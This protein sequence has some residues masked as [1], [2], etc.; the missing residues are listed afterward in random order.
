MKRRRR[1]R[2]KPVRDPRLV[3]TLAERNYQRRLPGRVIDQ[4]FVPYRDDSIGK[5]FDSGAQTGYWAHTQPVKVRGFLDGRLAYPSG[6]YD[7]YVFRVT[8][9]SESPRRPKG[10]QKVLG[11]LRVLQS[12]RP[13]HFVT[14]SISLRMESGCGDNIAQRNHTFFRPRYSGYARATGTKENSSRVWAFVRVTVG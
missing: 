13:S 4:A 3:Q 9:C 14:S 8:P 12:F 11:W 2:R 6:E 5:P 7:K 10:T 1:S